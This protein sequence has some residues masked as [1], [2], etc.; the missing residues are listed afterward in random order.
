MALLTSGPVRPARDL[1][2]N[3]ADLRAQVAANARGR[4]G[5][6]RMVADHGAAHVV[7]AYMGHVQDNAEEAVRRVLDALAAT[8]AAPRASAE[9][10]DGTAIAVRVTVDRG[11][12]GAASTSPARRRSAP[13]TST[14]RGR[15]DRRRALRLPHAGRRRHP[16]QRR[17]PRAAR[18]SSCRAG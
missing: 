2:Q 16:A 3:L 9:L 12:R 14:R 6:R 15:D 4:G 5:A 18:A 10:D 7:R 13:T 8:A 17:L 11:R 1:P